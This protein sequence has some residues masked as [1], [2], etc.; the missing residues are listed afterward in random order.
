MRF[1][2]T[3]YNP[4]TLLIL[5]CTVVFTLSSCRSSR[6]L[7]R[8]PF[9]MVIDAGHGGR[10]IGASGRKSNE[11]DINLKTA[12]RVSKLIRKHCRHVEVIMPEDGLKVRK[13]LSIHL[14]KVQK[15]N[16][17]PD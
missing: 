17:L 3:S 8:D 11:K 13:H 16:A 10:D 12:K 2:L 1:H 5:L 6:D 14:Q 9:I 7:R 15:V 4:V